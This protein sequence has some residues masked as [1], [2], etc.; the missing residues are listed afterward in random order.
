[1]QFTKCDKCHKKIKQYS[2]QVSVRFPG[3]DLFGTQLH[4]S[5]AKPILA[6]L[7][8]SRLLKKEKA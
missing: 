4:V 6:F 5:C 7:K 2:D 3:S 8:R 1:M